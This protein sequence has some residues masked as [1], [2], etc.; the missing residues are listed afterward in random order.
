MLGNNGLLTEKYGLL[1]TIRML[2]KWIKD[3]PIT[4]IGIICIGVIL[5]IIVHNTINPLTYVKLILNIIII[6]GIIAYANI[7]YTNM[8]Y[9]IKIMVYIKLF[10]IS[11]IFFIYNFIIYIFLLKFKGSSI[12]L[13]LNDLGLYI[14]TLCVIDILKNKNIIG[15]KYGFKTLFMYILFFIKLTLFIFVLRLVF[16]M[17]FGIIFSSQSVE[18]RANLLIVLNVIIKII[19]IYIIIIFVSEKDI[20]PDEFYEK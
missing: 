14:I 8:N 4:S 15:I 10:I 19:S 16:S 20:L 13:I 9:D 11:L 1:K 5:C 2:F 7:K 18:F 3:Y 6:I 17:L 12:L